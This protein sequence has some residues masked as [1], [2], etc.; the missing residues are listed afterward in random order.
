MQIKPRVLLQSALWIVFFCL[1]REEWLGMKLEQIFEVQYWQCVSPLISPGLQETP[2]ALSNF[3][4]PDPTNILRG[5]AWSWALNAVWWIQPNP[6]RHWADGQWT[7]LRTGL[8][9]VHRRFGQI[10]VT[11]ENAFSEQ[12]G[13]IATRENASSAHSRSGSIVLLLLTKS[14]LWE[15][16]TIYLCSHMYNMYA[17]IIYNKGRHWDMYLR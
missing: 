6:G 13:P 16:V 3:Q 5:S 2:W 1:F 7:Y 9:E 12:P 8:S 4:L 11:D 15:K 14:C 17:G 10:E